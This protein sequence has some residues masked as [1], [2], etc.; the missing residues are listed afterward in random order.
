MELM[1][2][3]IKFT[4]NTVKNSLE[5][6]DSISEQAEERISGL[7]EKAIEIIQS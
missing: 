4:K 5:G 3:I 6:P 2:T 1:R 7:E